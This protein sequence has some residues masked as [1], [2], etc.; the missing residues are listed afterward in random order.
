MWPGSGLSDW[1]ASTALGEFPARACVAGGTRKARA[2]ACHTDVTASG[3]KDR[4]DGRVDMVGGNAHFPSVFVSPG[5]FDVCF[6]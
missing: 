4:R 2:R 5:M 1:F 3:A 6:D